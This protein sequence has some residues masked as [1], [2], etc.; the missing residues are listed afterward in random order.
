M[1]L[2]KYIHY[3]IYLKSKLF[4]VNKIEGN[5]MFGYKSKL[6]ISDFNVNFTTIL[7][8]CI[9]E[10]FTESMVALTQPLD[11]TLAKRFIEIRSQG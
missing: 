8:R 6:Q 9:F 1:F 4:L 2:T 3:S 7:R 10:L 5:N 11:Q